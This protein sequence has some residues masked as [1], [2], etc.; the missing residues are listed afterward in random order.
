MTT[1]AVGDI[2][3]CHDVLVRLLARL[4]FDSDHDRLWVTGDLVNR[5]PQSLATLQT[6]HGLGQRA[7]AVLGNH[8]L[9]LLAVVH[10]AR[11]AGRNDTFQDVLASGQRDRYLGWLSNMPLLHDDPDLGFTMVH[12]GIVPQWTVREARE[13]AL[14]VETWLR[15]ERSGELFHHMYGDVPRQW[16]ESLEGWERLRFIINALTRLRYCTPAGALDLST[17]GPPGAQPAGYQPWYRIP[18]RAS[19]GRKIVFGHW[20]SLRLSPEEAKHYAA[21]HIDTGCVWG[22]ALTALDLARLRYVQEPAGDPDRSY[23]T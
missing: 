17:T 10:G 23:V 8:D 16:D 14:E 6:V 13:R 20:A 7:V 18:G 15:S 5:G 9:H 19:A 1:F 12:A 3:G 22:G 21:F 4:E 11:D 2:Q